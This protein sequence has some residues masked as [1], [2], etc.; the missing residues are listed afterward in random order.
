M[1][2]H[3]SQY[4]AQFWLTFIEYIFDSSAFD[5]QQLH[6]QICKLPLLVFFPLLSRAGKDT[7]FSSAAREEISTWENNIA[8]DLPIH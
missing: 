5:K 2:I 3:F 4:L 8:Q 1:S 7:E 6:Q